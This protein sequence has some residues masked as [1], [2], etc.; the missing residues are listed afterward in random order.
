MTIVGTASRCAIAVE[1]QQHVDDGLVT[2]GADRR[3]R[4]WRSP[5][6]SSTASTS[7]RPGT[8]IIDCKLPGLRFASAT[9]MTNLGLPRHR[10]VVAGRLPGCPPRPEPRSR[11]RESLTERRRAG[12]CAGAR[13]ASSLNV[14]CPERPY[15]G[16]PAA[17]VRSSPA[18]PTS[19]SSNVR[20]SSPRDR[21]AR[22]VAEVRTDD[23]IVPSRSA[24]SLNKTRT[25]V[26]TEHVDVKTPQCVVVGRR[27]RQTC[28]P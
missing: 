12:P 7:R 24:R 18:H 28:T 2:T 1:V 13:P 3:R 9:S 20:A 27:H 5:N 4:R 15:E 17:T 14:T 19:S 11:R 26:P 8:T 25:Y 23:R 22:D 16:S 21:T 10:R 6:R